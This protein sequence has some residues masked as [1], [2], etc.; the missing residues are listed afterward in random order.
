MV[1]RTREVLLQNMDLIIINSPNIDI[2]VTKMGEMVD[3]YVLEFV[4]QDTFFK[5]VPVGECNKL[6]RELKLVFRE[7]YV[8]FYNFLFFSLK[9]TG[10]STVFW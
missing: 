2:C 1:G 4:Q 9:G 3:R 10:F 5:A 8:N 7:R 6:K